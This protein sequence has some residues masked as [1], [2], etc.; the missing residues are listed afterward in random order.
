[1]RTVPYNLT[2]RVVLSICVILKQ[3]EVALNAGSKEENEKWHRWYILS[4][5]SA[6]ASVIVFILTEDMRLPMVWIDRWTF[7]MIV[8]VLMQAPGVFVKLR[9]KYEEEHKK[10]GYYA[11]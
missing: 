6:I 4:V 9:K 5:V 11:Q 3:N 8:L 7:L 1:M 2:D 10:Q